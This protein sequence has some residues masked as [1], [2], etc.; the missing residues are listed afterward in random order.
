M[1]H[2]IQEKINQV[3]RHVASWGKNIGDTNGSSDFVESVT[4]ERLEKEQELWRAIPS[5]PDLQCAWQL[6]LQCAG[7][8]C[9][10]FLRTVPPTQ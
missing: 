8:R 9:H 1:K 3:I 4:E 5:V 10:H 2:I 6:L 7:P